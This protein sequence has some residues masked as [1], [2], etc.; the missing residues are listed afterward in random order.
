MFA[1]TA[2]IVVVSPSFFH[3]VVVYHSDYC[4]GAANMETGSEIFVY[5][6]DK[7]TIRSA[8]M[9][10]LQ[11]YQLFFLLYYI[12]H[13]NNTEFI[14]QVNIKNNGNDSNDT[15]KMTVSACLDNKG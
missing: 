11:H 2:A 3:H 12:R 5:F 7:T 15:T 4:G 1:A 9:R 10:R 6:N 13:N 14:F 8:S